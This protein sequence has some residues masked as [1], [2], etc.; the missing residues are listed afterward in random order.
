ME[1]LPRNCAAMPVF[2]NWT[3]VIAITHFRCCYVLLLVSYNGI[4]IVVV[5]DRVV[6][7][8][9]ASMTRWRSSRSVVIHVI[10]IVG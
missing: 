2:N 4:I 8:T 3:V 10:V 7:V 6:V 9:A 5:V 1:Y